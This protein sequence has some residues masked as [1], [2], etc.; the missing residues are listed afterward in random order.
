MESAV[1]F[2]LTVIST[3]AFYAL[4]AWGLGLI[5]GQLNVVNVAHGDLAMVGAYTMFVLEPVI[6]FFPRILVALIVGL[7]VGLAAERLLLARLYAQ[8]MLAT[9]LAM[10]G[11]G[12]VLRQLAEAI[13]GPTPA[14]VSA[15]ITGSI[16][17]LGTTYPAYRLVAA[18]LCL[19]IVAACLATVFLTPLGLRLRAS[20]D[21]R[22][23]AASLGIPPTRMITGAFMLGTTL[24]VLAGALQSPML[25]VT[26]SA[27]VGLLAPAFF[28]VMLGRRGSMISPVVGAFVVALL[29]TVLRTFLPETAAG[30]IFFVALIALIALRPQGLDWRFPSWKIPRTAIA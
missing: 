9:L 29:D 5:F 12:I 20:I 10:W 24:A 23:M 26:P 27:G 13:F 22:S 25:G 11:V 14:S 8:G 7:V 1:L 19:M 3:F 4:L 21:N 30:L 18:A 15:P 28:A 2:S 16:E 6:P 17:V